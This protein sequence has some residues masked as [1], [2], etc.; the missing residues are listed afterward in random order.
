MVPFIEVNSTMT[1]PYVLI[2]MR[3]SERAQFIL[4]LNTGFKMI[5]D[6]K[7]KSND[8]ENNIEKSEQGLMLLKNESQI[9]DFSNNDDDNDLQPLQMTRSVSYS[10]GGSKLTK[11]CKNLSNTQEKA[12]LQD[13]L[14]NY[15]KW[16]QSCKEVNNNDVK[17]KNCSSNESV[18]T[19]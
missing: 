3:V 15:R 2:A 19:F 13:W 4:K 14:Y 6:I 9:N 7:L 18:I 11:S 8:S 17:N 12:G 1:S 5:E 10:F 16:K